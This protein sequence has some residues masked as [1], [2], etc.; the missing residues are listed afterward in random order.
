MPE[1]PADEASEQ[2]FQ[3]QVRVVEDGVG[4]LVWDA[5]VDE[6]LLVRSV[7]LASDDA[8]LAHD[9][10]RLEASVLA[11]DLA[12]RRALQ[13]AGYRQ[14]GIRREAQQDGDEYLDVVVYARLAADQIYGPGGFSGVMNSVLPTKRVIAHVLFTDERG[15]ALLLETT[16][17]SD[18]EL[19]GGV[20]EPNE[21]PREGAIR[22]VVEE[23]G[24]LVNLGNPALVDWMPPHLGWS[25]AIEFIYDGGV[26]DA[27][28]CDRMRLEAREIRAAHW[29]SPRDLDGHVSELSARRIRAI[30]AARAHGRVLFTENGREP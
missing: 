24:L 20:V 30:L 2:E 25:D 5:T 18:F 19:P 11:H 3:I 8:L 12:A 15:R 13:R 26:L 4:L 17:K 21:P 16:Y 23:I 6:E 7:S 22:E 28:A 27:T 29:L 14:E 1:S 9:L 10:R